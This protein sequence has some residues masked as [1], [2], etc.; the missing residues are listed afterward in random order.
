MTL[1]VAVLP[2]T[3][4]TVI[5]A[6]PTLIPFIT[7]LLTVTTLLLLDVHVNALFVT[8]AGVIVAFKVVLLSL[9]MV[10]VVLSSLRFIIG[11]FII[12]FALT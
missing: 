6:V 4:F 9:L 3:V 5:V 2:L 1:Q 11:I 8:L 10:N 7:P 12:G